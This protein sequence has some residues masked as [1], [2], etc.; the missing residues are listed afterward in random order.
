MVCTPMPVKLQD[1]PNGIGA[2]LNT[3]AMQ[4][5]HM[6]ITISSSN[7]A[8]ETILPRSIKRDV[9][10]AEPVKIAVQPATKLVTGI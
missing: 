4:P 7:L 5:D 6:T 2:P 3:Q 8:T 10:R 1:V 9:Q